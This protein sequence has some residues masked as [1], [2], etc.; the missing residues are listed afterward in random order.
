MGKA[1]SAIRF[2]T[3]LLPVANVSLT[4]SQLSTRCVL[5][6]PD[7]RLASI[8]ARLASVCFGCPTRTTRRL[9]KFSSIRFYALAANFAPARGLT[10][11]FSKAVLGMLLIW[12]RWRSLNLSTAQ[13]PTEF[14]SLNLVLQLL[15]FAFRA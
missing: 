4:L 13:C 3:G 14:P 10:E 1:R 7:P 9:A 6:V 5:G 2:L 8:I 12:C 15:L 11:L